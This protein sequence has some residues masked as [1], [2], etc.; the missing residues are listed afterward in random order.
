MTLGLPFFMTTSCH[1]LVA[2][3]PSQST[4]ISKFALG[5][6]LPHLIV[7]RQLRL[8][9]QFVSEALRTDFIITSN[10]VMNQYLK[11]G[12]SF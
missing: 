12:F 4:L 11:K 10:Y 9:P 5:P 7:C 6:T 8:Q 2:A 1:L 3:A